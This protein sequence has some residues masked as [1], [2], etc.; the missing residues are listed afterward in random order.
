[1]SPR[2]VCSVGQDDEVVRPRG[3]FQ[4]CCPRYASPAPSAVSHTFIRRDV[5][6]DK[7]GG[8]PVDVVCEAHP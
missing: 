4:P 5:V 7:L 2:M 6:G 3:G 1:M 8:T